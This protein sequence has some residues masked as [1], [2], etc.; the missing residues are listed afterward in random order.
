VEEF[1]GSL[2]VHLACTSPQFV[3]RSIERVESDSA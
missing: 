2:K 3:I 1:S